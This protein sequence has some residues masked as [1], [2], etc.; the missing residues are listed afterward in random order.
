VKKLIPDISK[1]LIPDIFGSPL[2]VRNEEKKG[3]DKMTCIADDAGP[4]HRCGMRQR[5]AGHV[6]VKSRYR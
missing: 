3:G 1:K 5:G 2:A 6:E 4:S